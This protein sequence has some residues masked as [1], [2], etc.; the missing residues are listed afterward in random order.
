MKNILILEVG[1]IRI[2]TVVLQLL[3]LKIYTGHTAIYELGVYYFLFTLSYSL[4]AFLLV[5]IDYF[6]QSQLY[7][8]KQNSFSLKSFF[9]INKKVLQIILAV[10]LIATIVCIIIN[11]AYVKIVPLVVFLSLSTYIVTLLRGFINNFEQRR[12]AIYTLLFESS[13]KIGFYLFYVKFFKPSA[14]L[15]LVSLLSAS[16][17]ALIALTFIITKTTEYKN[18]SIKTFNFSEITKF[19]YP[20]SM[21]AVI[22][23]IQL[24]GY[25]MILVPLGLIEVVGIYGTVANVGTSGMNAF[26]TI[27]TQLFVPNLYKSFGSYL[28]TYLTYAILCISL[29]LTTGLL[30]SNLIISL[31]TKQVFVKYSGLIVYGIISEAGNFLIGALT[32]YLSIKNLTKTTF[33]SS[34]AGLIAFFL[35]FG[36]LYTTNR[37]SVYTIGLPIVFT[38]I[39]VTTYLGII[40]YQSKKKEYAVS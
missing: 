35:S 19:T 9:D 40:V 37:I 30:F 21:S 20:I 36:A 26:S 15:I 29:V 38:Q 27:Y 24:Q 31:L 12:T 3:F 14:I 18:G 6:Q 22:N 23:W 39:I 2:I 13:L 28:K 33:E 1:A 5:P 34:M 16:V 25:R 17:I 11:P 4:N 7:F 32:I 10:T 8:L